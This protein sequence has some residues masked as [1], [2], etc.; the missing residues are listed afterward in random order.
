MMGGFSLGQAAPCLKN[1][2]LGKQAGYRVFKVLDN[3]PVISPA[4]EKGE[5]PDHLQGN[6]EL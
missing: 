4:Y 3:K 5:K 6:I 2:G 1:F